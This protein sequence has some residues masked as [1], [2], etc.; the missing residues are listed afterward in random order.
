MQEEL[1]EFLNTSKSDLSYHYNLQFY[2]SPE[3][4]T[5][6]EIDSLKLV[7]FDNLNFDCKFNIVPPKN[8]FVHIEFTDLI[9]HGNCDHNSIK[10]YS[11]FSLKDEYLNIKYFYFNRPS[12]FIRLCASNQQQNENLIIAEFFEESIANS[13]FNCFNSKNK[14]CFLTSEISNKLNPSKKKFK[15]TN[16]FNN[17]LIEIK[18]DKLKLFH[19]EIKYNFFS[20][21]LP[22]Y[23][24]DI[25][26][27]NYREQIEQ[28]S[29]QDSKHLIDSKSVYE[30]MYANTNCDFKCF[31]LQDEQ[32]KSSKVIQMCIDS[33]LVCDDDV[34]CTHN[35][36][37]EANCNFNQKI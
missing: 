8:N 10:L 21:N 35:G 36:L 32:N 30:S 33:S 2:Q 17:L 25:I 28:A 20:I 37:D 7:L 14:I 11:N 24:N 22:T 12:P 9:L 6:R 27:K 31:T 23:R 29:R 1:I 16:F 19:F 5:Q 15:R 13:S 18:S 34:H 3:T 4:K 26:E